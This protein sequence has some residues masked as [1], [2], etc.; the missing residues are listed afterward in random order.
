MA[1]SLLDARG[2]LTEAGLSALAAAP[3]GRGPKELAAHLASCPRCQERMLA[4]T[5]VDL[6]ARRERREPPPPWRIWAV[7]GAA[8]LLLLSILMTIRRLLSV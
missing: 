7:L 6:P 8:V 3:P 2:H 4:G 5:G 1:G